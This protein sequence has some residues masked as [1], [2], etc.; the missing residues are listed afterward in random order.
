MRERADLE[1]LR[2][3]RQLLRLVKARTSRWA[4]CPCAQLVDVDHVSR[5]CVDHQLPSAQE[6]E[7]AEDAEQ[8]RRRV[9]CSRANRKAINKLMASRD[10][11]LG[12]PGTIRDKNA[13]GASPPRDRSSRAADK[14][15]VARSEDFPTSFQA[16]RVRYILKVRRESASNCS[17]LNGGRTNLRRL[18]LMFP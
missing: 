11:A 5:L 12:E 18:I 14:L 9:S 8:R 4:R 16:R 15:R 7:L 10:I 13:R 6:G 3:R 1:I 2:G 17:I